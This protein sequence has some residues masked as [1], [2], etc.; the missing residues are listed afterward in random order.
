M[1]TNNL[2]APRIDTQLTEGRRISILE[3]RRRGLS[4]ADAE[5][6]ASC[7]SIKLLLAIRKGQRIKSVEAWTRTATRNYVVN[8]HRDASRLKRGGGIVESL[9]GVSED[10][11]A[12]P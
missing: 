10:R 4:H 6:V 9:T 3:A 5:D 12:R 11:F 8:Q 1:P 7:V 2:D